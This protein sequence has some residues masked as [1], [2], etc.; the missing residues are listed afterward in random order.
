VA[1]E[2]KIVMPFAAALGIGKFVAPFLGSLFGGG[3]PE[4][5]DLTQNT[6]DT[7]NMVTGALR[8]SQDKRD[9]AGRM[10]NKLAKTDRQNARA[11]GGFDPRMLQAG[12][13]ADPGNPF[14]HLTGIAEQFGD[15]DFGA[16][17]L[18]KQFQRESQLIQLSQQIASLAP[19]MNMGIEQLLA[20]AGG[21]AGQG[22]GSAVGGALAGLSNEA[23]LGTGLGGF[24]SGLGGPQTIAAP[25]AVDASGLMGALPGVL[26]A[27]PGQ[28]FDNSS[29]FSPIIQSILQGTA[30]SNEGNI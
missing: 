15:V 7:S 21:Q 30:P 3:A 14:A 27:A 24:L 5:G 13:A 28:T 22:M 16:N 4:F 6:K 8:Q 11:V 17:A 29:V 23:T 25:G 26:E 20:N 10:S 12:L 9:R 18:R 1:E 19:S 2:E